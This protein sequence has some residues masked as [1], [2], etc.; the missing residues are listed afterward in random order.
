MDRRN[1]LKHA[2]GAGV[3]GCLCAEI[4]VSAAAGE[5][6]KE[7]TEAPAEKK[8]EPTDWRWAFVKQ[9]Y[10]FLMKLLHKQLGPG[11]FSKMIQAM[12]R[13]C[14][15]SIDRISKYKGNPDGYFKMLKEHWND[16]SD[17][18]KEKGVIRIASAERT[19]C[20][21]PLIDTKSMP[22]YVCDCSL[23]WQKQTFETVFGKKADVKIEESILR[24][25]KRC[26]FTITL[27]S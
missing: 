20:F 2:C 25:G 11:R 8:T 17:Y 12:G 16:D 1:L 10:L 18:D 21:C 13:D 22:D 27:K 19:E 14:S 15:T 6:K 3:C 23:G 24:G 7:N 4:L 5:E 9:R 26:V